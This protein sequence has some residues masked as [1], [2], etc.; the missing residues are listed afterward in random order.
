LREKSFPTL[1]LRVLA[2]GFGAG[3]SPII[4]GTAGTLV[5]VPLYMLLA[6]MGIVAVALALL[7]A[8]LVG[9]YAAGRMERLSGKQDPGTV[10]IDEIAGY[11]LTM[12]GSPADFFHLTAGF[13]LF[14]LFDVLKPPPARQAEKRLSGGTGIMID[15]LLAACY[16]W[17]CLRGME[18]LFY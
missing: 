4:P 13:F 12:I 8:V 14:R 1:I 16:A 7:S 2:T 11:L 15:D 5:G 3:Y 18:T 9:V 10:V 17:L 6:P